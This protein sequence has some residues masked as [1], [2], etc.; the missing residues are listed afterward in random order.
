MKTLKNNL[1]SI[2]FFFCLCLAILSFSKCG[3][4]EEDEPKKNESPCADFE[5][6]NGSTPFSDVEFGTCGCICPTGYSGQHCEIK[7]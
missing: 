4:D 5:C 7:N 3:S 1:K 2:A 6:L